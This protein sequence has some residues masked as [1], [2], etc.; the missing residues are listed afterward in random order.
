M[1]EPVDGARAR[2]AMQQTLIG[3]ALYAAA[4]ALAF[5]WSPGAVGMQVIAL[6]LFIFA[7]PIVPSATVDA[8]AMPP[9]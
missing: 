8:E 1:L 2:A 7:P 4:L 3:P 6:A 9:Q 5:I